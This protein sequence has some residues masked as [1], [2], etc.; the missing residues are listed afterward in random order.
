MSGSWEHKRTD[1]Q[2][3]LAALAF[4]VGNWE[5]EG[6]AEDKVIRGHIQATMQLGATFLEVRETLFLPDGTIDHADICFY[7]YDAGQQQ[8][9]VLQMVEPAWTAERPVVLLPGGGLRWFDGP[10]GPQVSLVPDGD[11]LVVRVTLPNVLRPVVSM[12]YRHA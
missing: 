9:R 3:K 6:H 12:R 8:L 10:L 4:L 2:Q 5:G 11:T 7:R 1:A